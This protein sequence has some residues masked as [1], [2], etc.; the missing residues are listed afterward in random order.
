[1]VFGEE[2]K[3]I[4]SGPSR[5]EK[6]K[7]DTW[8]HHIGPWIFSKED[9]RRTIFPSV[10]DLEKDRTSYVALVNSKRRRRNHDPELHDLCYRR[11]R[12]IQFMMYL[13]EEER[14]PMIQSVKSFGTRGRNHG[15]GC[16]TFV[17]KKTFLVSPCIFDK[18]K[19]TP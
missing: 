16:T 7:E 11:R 3:N 1:M 2:Q 12:H 6:A 13:R 10:R 14:R 8:T 15:L 19:E 5:F 9:E 4:K 18:K 17:Q